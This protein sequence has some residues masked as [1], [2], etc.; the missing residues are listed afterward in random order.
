[1]IFFPEENMDIMELQ[2]DV[3]SVKFELRINS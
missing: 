3:N 2:S 1:M